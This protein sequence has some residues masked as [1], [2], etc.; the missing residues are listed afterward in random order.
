M[1]L[2]HP[3]D[4]DSFQQNF[5]FLELNISSDS[6]ILRCDGDSSVFHKAGLSPPND[7]QCSVYLIESTQTHSTQSKYSDL[8]CT[9]DGGQ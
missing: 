5:S 8:I 4:T 3:H 1:N 2:L 9:F 7:T 6:N